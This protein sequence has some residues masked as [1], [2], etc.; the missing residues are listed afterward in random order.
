M[1]NA[2]HVRTS[3][4]SSRHLPLRHGPM[5]PTV[6]C[7]GGAAH[8]V[9]AGRFAA[10]VAD[11]WDGLAAAWSGERGAGTVPASCW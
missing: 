9:H 6:A 1:L 5:P 11:R 8:R 2:A 7:A 10:N 4:T 3:A